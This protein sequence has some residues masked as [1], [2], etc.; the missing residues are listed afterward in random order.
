MRKGFE[1]M[2]K[3]RKGMIAVF[4]LAGFSLNAA[5]Q[6]VLFNEPTPW[7]TQRSDSLLIK[8]QVDTAQIKKKE[9]S[10]SAFTMIKG[11]QAKI[12]SKVFKVNDLS[13]D[14]DLGFAKTALLGGYDY[15]KIEW[16]IPGAK[17][18]GECVP[19]GIVDLTKLPAPQQY[20][21]AKNTGA[22][23]EKNLGGI[24]ESNYLAVG[25]FKCA[26]VWNEKNLGVAIQKSSV[27]KCVMVC[28]DGKNG[29]NAFLSYPD[30]LIK[31][32]PAKDSM[33]TV[34]VER[35]LAN[36]AITYIEKGW[37]SE[38]VKSTGSS[39]AAISAPLADLGV[40][41]FD[42]RMVGFAV[43]V[44]DKDGKQIAALPAKAVKEIPGTWANL[45]FAK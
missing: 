27:E 6:I 2:I 20:T 28:V 45:V 37:N 1:G 19:V 40:V 33:A 10:V 25:E 34:H 3:S 35:S 16:S 36:N 29:K 7:I 38:T 39:I 21:A 18:K 11:K 4:A 22:F 14:F 24:A 12:S 44:L 8:A 5:A 32:F 17:D 26:L 43:F 13:K 31:Y 9:V 41:G 23:D 15:L 30:R 42:G